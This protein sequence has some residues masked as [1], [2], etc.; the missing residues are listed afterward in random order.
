MNVCGFNIFSVDGDDYLHIL[1]E[2]IDFFIGLC[3]SVTYH[4]INKTMYKAKVIVIVLYLFVLQNNPPY[5]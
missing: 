4:S 1:V 2:L 5:S 3:S